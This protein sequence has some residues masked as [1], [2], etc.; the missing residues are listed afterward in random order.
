MSGEKWQQYQHQRNQLLRNELILDHLPLVKYVAGR[1]AVRLPTSVSFEDLEGW[2]VFGLMD[3]VDKFDPSQGADFKTYAYHR[4]RGAILDELRRQS[5]VPRTL[6]HK[7]QNINEVRER[8]ENEAGESVPDKAVADALGLTPEE[9]HQLCGH[10]QRIA[11]VSLDDVRVSQDAEPVTWA[12]LIE[13]RSSP[14]PIEKVLDEE[15]WEALIEAINKL[16]ERDKLILGLYYQEGLTL[17]EMGAVL[18]V[19]ESRVCQLHSRAINRLRQQLAS[20]G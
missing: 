6:W 18:E 5:W 7:L 17:K 3:A 12:E 16:D 10:F 4:I 19:T 2:G 20:R 15:N 11:L 1:L 14:D 8:L 13:D 9:Y